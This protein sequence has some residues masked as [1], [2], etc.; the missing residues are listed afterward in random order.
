M[1]CCGISQRKRYFACKDE[2]Q[3]IL[4][5]GTLL[6]ITVFMCVLHQRFLKRFRIEKH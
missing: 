4:V 1:T 5:S 3:Q 2:G 6:S